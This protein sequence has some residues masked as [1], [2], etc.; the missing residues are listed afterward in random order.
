MEK[1][2]RIPF[3]ESEFLLVYRCNKCGEKIHL[4]HPLL[5]FLIQ[6]RELRRPSSCLDCGNT[7][8]FTFLPKES[9]ISQ[10]QEEDIKAF[11]KA[12]EGSDTGS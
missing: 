10:I 4:V 7:T 8:D 2:V 12:A 5:D 9:W 11:L 1:P 6:V 3:M